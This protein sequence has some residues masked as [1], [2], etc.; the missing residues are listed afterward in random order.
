MTGLVVALGILLAVV[1]VGG[2]LFNPDD[3]RRR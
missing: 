2:V 3:W 1:I